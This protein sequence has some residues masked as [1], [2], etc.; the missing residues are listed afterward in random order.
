MC[1][2]H[3]QRGFTLLELMVVVVIAALL[4]TFVALSINPRSAGDNLK[5]EALRFH[6]LLQL[7]L[8]EAVLKGEDYGIEIA[9]R[10]YRFLR[11]SDNRW[12]PIENDKV[13][14]Q[15]ELPEEMLMELAVE[16]TDIVIE[17][18]NDDDNGDD[19]DKRE[20]ILPQVFLLS[21]GE[22]TPEFSLQ[23][24]YPTLLARYQVSAAFNGDISSQQIE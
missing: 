15:R 18:S 13:L 17:R 3:R 4:F 1:A 11:R 6:R 14:R 22:I 12:V 2:Q 24:Y 8:D 20:V 9:M 23:F 7:L 19:S 10:E 16:S 21:S 5:Q